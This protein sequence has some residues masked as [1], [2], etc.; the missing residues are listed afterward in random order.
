MKK[1]KNCQNSKTQ[2]TNTQPSDHKNTP[3]SNHQSFRVLEKKIR[4]ENNAF[5]VL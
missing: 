3:N 1:M 5:K 2:N 4:M